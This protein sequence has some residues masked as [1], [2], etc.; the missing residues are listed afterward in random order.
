MWDKFGVL[1]RWSL[2]RGSNYRVLSE[3]NLV[4]LHRWSLTIGSNYRVLCGINLVFC[5]GGRLWEVVAE[6]VSTVFLRKKWDYPLS[7]KNL[8]ICFIC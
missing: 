4:F 6:R 7:N 3:I 5:I 8:A 2:T 1:H